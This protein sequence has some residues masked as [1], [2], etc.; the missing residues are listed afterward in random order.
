MAGSI[1]N[2]TVRSLN[3]D[4]KGVSFERLEQSKPLPTQDKGQIK[5]RNLGDRVSV[6]K[7]ARV[8]SKPFNKLEHTPEVRGDMVAF[9][10]ALIQNGALQVN[11]ELIAWNILG[12]I[13]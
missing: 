12:E 11:P 3:H 5:T 7:S 1:P 9:Y 4:S 13:V 2:G 6:S 10:K 8:L